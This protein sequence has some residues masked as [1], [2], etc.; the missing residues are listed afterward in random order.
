MS[1]SK[2]AKDE[3]KGQVR[4]EVGVG[5]RKKSETLKIGVRYTSFLVK[6]INKDHVSSTKVQNNLRS[7]YKLYGLRKLFCTFVVIVP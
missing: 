7:P 4:T 5:V 2:I 6:P 3:D 1:L